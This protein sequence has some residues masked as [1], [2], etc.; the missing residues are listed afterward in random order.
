MGTQLRQNDDGSLGLRSDTAPD[1]FDGAFV[2]VTFPYNPASV[3]QTIFYSHRRYVIKG[4]ALRIDSTGTDAAA[5]TA[6][7]RTYTGATAVASGT[8]IGGSM[9]LKG[10]V[11]VWTNAAAGTVLT[12]GIMVGVDF[13]G[14]LTTA[15]GTITLTLAPA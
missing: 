2:V 10:A 5:V 13:T 6:Q 4:A 8:A 14:V 1:S 15:S 12:L 7:L 11:G 3:D 9:D